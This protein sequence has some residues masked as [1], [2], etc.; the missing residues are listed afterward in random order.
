MDAEVRRHV[1]GRLGEGAP[2]PTVA[3]TAAA[4]GAA[5]DDVERSYRRLHELRALV[6]RPGTS[7]IW[8]AHPFSAVP[9]DFSVEAA[10]GRRWWANCAWDALGIPAATGAD[11][12][13]ATRCGDC[14]EPIELEVR[15]GRVVP[16]AAVTL[17][18]VPA[19]RWWDDV[20]FT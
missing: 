18:V 7:E 8:M 1:Y 12:L 4:L 11:A 20:G 16:A 19:A 14:G 2:A 9:T 6:L 10:D 13:V 15:G 5:A 3:E 17:F